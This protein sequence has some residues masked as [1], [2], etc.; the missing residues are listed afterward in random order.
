[1][2]ILL[3]LLAAATLVAQEP[4]EPPR[5]DKYK[6]DPG[7]YCLPSAPVESDK[8]GHECHCELMC[9]DNG[10]GEQMPRESNTCELYCTHE[11]CAC[12]PDNPCASEPHPKA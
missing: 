5:H 2:R 3:C 1:M 7:A 12:H 8:H 4:T 11:R 6:D 10:Q 9:I